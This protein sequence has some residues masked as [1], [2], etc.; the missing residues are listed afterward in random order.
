MWKGANKKERLLQSNRSSISRA[1]VKNLYMALAN[2]FT[3]N[4][5]L[6]VAGKHNSLFCFPGHIKGIPA[7]NDRD[8]LLWI[9]FRKCLQMLR[10]K[11]ECCLATVRQQA[12]CCFCCFQLKK[13]RCFEMR[14]RLYW[15]CSGRRGGVCAL[16]PRLRFVKFVTENRRILHSAF[17]TDEGLH[18]F[19]NL[20]WRE[21]KKADYCIFKAMK[22]YIFTSRPIYSAICHERLTS[23]WAS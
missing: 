6:T 23:A 5:S 2:C 11:S 21:D 7:L 22:V 8:K 10:K 4:S 17:L 19:H 16:F 20:S 14:K 3:N 18:I 13:Q 1:P 15:C 12:L 9:T